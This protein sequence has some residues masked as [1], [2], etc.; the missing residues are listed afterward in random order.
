MKILIL[1]QIISLILSVT[2]PDVV[3]K[4]ERQITD[5][6]NIEQFISEQRVIRI[7]YYD[8]EKDE[9][10]IVPLDYGFLIEEDQYTFY[11]HGGPKGR[12]YELTK[13]EP[14][15]GFEIDG[16]YQ[17]VPGETACQHSAKYQSIIG[18]GKIQLLNDIE[19]KKI[20]L[21]LIMKH[22]TGKSGFEYVPKMLEKVAIYKL[23]ATK[24]TCKA[25]L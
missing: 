24:L 2:V 19:E 3:R 18:N 1:L 9:V 10:Y 4:K 12:K 15:V 23:T 21:D 7:G 14:N 8:K 16:N 22:A 11:M 20:A 6:K 5:K 17:L 13:D 25:N